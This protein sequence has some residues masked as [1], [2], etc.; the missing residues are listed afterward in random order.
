MSSTRRKTSSARWLSFPACLLSLL[1][2][3]APAAETV[4]TRAERT[5]AAIAAFGPRAAGTPAEQRVAELV[6]ARL[7]ELGYEV[8]IQPVVLPRGGSSRNIVA[9][10]PGPAR[11]VVV[12]HLDGVRAGPAANDNGSGVAVLLE[13]AR[14]LRGQGGLL[15]AAVGAEERAETQSRLHLGSARLVESL[16]SA[17]RKAIRLALALDMVGY[18][19]TLNVRGLESAPNRSAR[20][21]L[22]HG[23]L[24]L[25]DRG[26]SDHAELTR[27]GIPAAW[28]EWREDPCWHA[29]C[30]TA[31]RVKPWKLGAAAR[32]ALAA[33]R[34]ALG[35]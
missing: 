4:G 25:Q 13:L 2:S 21:V 29:A 28:I 27:A 17:D 34:D 26:E 19:G 6:A 30:D 15:L 5:V 32:L 8:E 16:S 23:G 9:R 3:P 12:A 7:H 18:G 24:Y 35:P 33:I 10:T 14:A 22:E 11:V 20:L 31:D 1:V